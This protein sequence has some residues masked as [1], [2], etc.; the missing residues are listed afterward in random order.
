MFDMLT[1][2]RTDVKKKKREEKI[3][4]FSAAARQQQDVRLHQALGLPALEEG[5]R[6]SLVA[7]LDVSR[8]RRLF[9]TPF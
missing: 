6:D 7:E 5:K 1:H 8:L 2:V 9:S 4:K 3:G